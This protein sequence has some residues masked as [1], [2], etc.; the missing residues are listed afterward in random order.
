MNQDERI[1]N[2]EIK[3]SFSEDLLEELNQTVFKQQQR[4]ELLV[5]E[6]QALKLQMASNMPSDGNSPRD[7]IP[8]HY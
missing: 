5:K 6:I 3:L 7:E 1:T 8:P 4:I 2:L